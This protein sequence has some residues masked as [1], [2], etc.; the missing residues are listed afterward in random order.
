MLKFKSTLPL[1]QKDLSQ[2]AHQSKLPPSQFLAQHEDLILLPR[3]VQE[4]THSPLANNILAEQMNA[5][6]KRKLID[7]YEIT[8]SPWTLTVR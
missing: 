6:G 7:E 1:L 2:L 3:D 4:K 5:N 8:S